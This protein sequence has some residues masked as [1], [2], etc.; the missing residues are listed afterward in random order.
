[1]NHDLIDTHY[2]LDPVVGTLLDFGCIF[3]L[4]D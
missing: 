1:M 2:I 4:D 3:D